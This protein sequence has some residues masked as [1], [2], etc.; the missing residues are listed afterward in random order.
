MAFSK[1]L[2]SKSLIYFVVSSLI[3]GTHE[4]ED[5]RFE[6]LPFCNDQIKQDKK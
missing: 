4:E 3:V 1:F 5:V 2:L 6:S